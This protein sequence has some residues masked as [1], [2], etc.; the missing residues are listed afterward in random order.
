MKRYPF[1]FILSYFFIVTSAYSATLSEVK[2]NLLTEQKQ[3]KAQTQERVQL[4][5]EISDYDKK[6]AQILTHLEVYSRQTKQIDAEIQ[7]LEQDILNLNEKKKNQKDLL[8]EQL[9][10]VF[11][12]GRSGILDLIFN[13][14]KTL[15]NERISQYYSYLNKAREKLIIELNDTNLLLEEKLESLNDKKITQQKLIDKQQIEKN[16]LETNQFA[17]EKKRKELEVAMQLSQGRITQLKEEET[18]L[19]NQIRLAEQKHQELREKE[20]KKADELRKKNTE[21][22]TKE[23]TQLIA[24]VNGLGSPKNQFLFPVKGSLEYKFGQRI[25]EQLLWKGLVIRAKEG[26]PVKA[27]DDGKV[28]LANWLE[29]YGF[30]VVLD[31]GKG[32]MSLY[33]YNQR[34][35]A[36]IGDDITKGSTIAYVGN[37]GGEKIPALYFEIRRNGKAQNPLPWLKAI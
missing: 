34:I 37:T 21:T 6:I 1:L 24:R 2:S 10:A 14:K 35:T 29:G 36:K 19:L 28:I 17:R 15:E 9:N 11:K 23:E 31:H 8:A 32:D 16:M 25:N 27:I 18:A 12:I 7:R 4:N 5:K 3:L 26:D 30:I 20:Q 22:L 13:P 33:G